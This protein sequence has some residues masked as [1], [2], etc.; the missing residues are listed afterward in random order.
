M[1]RPTLRFFLTATILLLMTCASHAQSQTLAIDAFN[2]R[3]ATKAE[4]SPDPAILA[5]I[6]VKLGQ[7]NG[8]FVPPEEA[9]ETSSYAATELPAGQYAFE[10]IASVQQQLVAGL[11]SEG[12]GGIA[13]VPSA[14]DFDVTTNSDRRSGRGD[15]TLLIWLASVDNIRTV[16]KGEYDVVED[17]LVDRDEHAFIRDSSPLEP[18]T[19]ISQT[20]MESHLSRV[21]MHPN[22]R[23]DLSVS[24]ADEPGKVNVD[25]LVTESRPWTIYAQ[26]SN[27]GTESTGEFRQRLG[28]AHTNLIGFDDILSVDFITSKFDEA[29]AVSGSYQFPIFRPEWLEAKV[30]GSWNEFSATNLTIPTNPDF[31]G[32]T[33]TFGAELISTPFVYQNY[34]LTVAGGFRHEQHQVANVFSVNSGGL[35]DLNI[36]YG[37]LEVKKVAGLGASYVNATF[38]RNF[39][40]IQQVQRVQFD[41]Q[42]FSD[43][44]YLLS[45][46]AAHTFFPVK[47]FTGFDPVESRKLYAYSN[48]LQFRVRG[49]YVFENKRV[50]PQKRATGGGFFTVRG[51]P[52]SAAAGEKMVVGSAEY[53]LN[54]PYLLDPE[55]EVDPTRKRE[56]NFEGFKFTP[57]NDYTRPDW[58]L[59]LR[60]FLDYGW[61]ER[62]DLI[63]GDTQA[64]MLGA[65][66]GAEISILDGYRFR[67][68]YA[69]AL[70]DLASNIAGQPPR[71]ESGEN[72]V[73]FLLTVSY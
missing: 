2:Y 49:Q 27:T 44:Y 42:D 72:R 13:V 15:F 20:S 65:G 55:S 43:R 4:A 39:S 17:Q 41:G 47:W 33:V 28:G 48:E 10:A 37:R 29:N 67:I 6:S 50:I 63:S 1:P 30:F 5:D 21:N 31:E 19:T 62:N 51:Y 3:F 24:P 34:A 32:E 14:E 52:E 53:T 59:A 70:R 25:Y 16:A 57:T 56:D 22:R 46:D 60:G 35:A 64:N 18:G 11:T 66:V 26:L 38:E 58:N 61:V 40:G 7:E 9:A 45:G 73:H 12:F 69:Y 71:A 8:V 68:D 36:G 23:V 54:I